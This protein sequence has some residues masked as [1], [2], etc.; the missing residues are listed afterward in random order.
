MQRKIEDHSSF[1]NCGFCTR[2][3]KGVND[4]FKRAFKTLNLP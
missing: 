2:S 1:L 3:N 4:A